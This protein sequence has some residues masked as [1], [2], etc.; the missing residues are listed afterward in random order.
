MRQHTLR[1]WVHDSVFELSL[2]PHKTAFELK[3]RSK[4][5]RKIVSK[6]CILVA[7]KIVRGWYVVSILME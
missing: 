2:G 3:Q 4:E 7:L 5:C 6:L 1:S